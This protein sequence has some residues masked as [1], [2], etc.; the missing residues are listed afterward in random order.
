MSEILLLFTTRQPAVTDV[1]DSGRNVGALR[2][3]RRVGFRSVA[4]GLAD[5][6]FWCCINFVMLVLHLISNV[7]PNSKRGKCALDHCAGL[8]CIE[9]LNIFD[10]QFVILRGR[11]KVF[12]SP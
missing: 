1:F 9:N 3:A 7:A 2:P 8:T 11:I 10:L 5:D 4:P 12:F 6:I